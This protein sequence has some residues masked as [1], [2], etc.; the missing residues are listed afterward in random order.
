MACDRLM[1]LT[2]NKKQMGCVYPN[3]DLCENF[4]PVNRTCKSF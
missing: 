3:G 1:F 2:N 4:M